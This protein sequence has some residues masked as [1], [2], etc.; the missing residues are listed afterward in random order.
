[1]A[2]QKLPPSAVVRGTRAAGGLTSQYSTCN[3]SVARQRCGT[4]DRSERM[5]MPAAVPG[6]LLVL[7]L[8][9]SHSSRSMWQWH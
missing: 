6:L 3:C 1:V 8:L 4:D 9:R 2:A 5:I 7:L